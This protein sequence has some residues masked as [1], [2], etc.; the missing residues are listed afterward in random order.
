MFFTDCASFLISTAAGIADGNGT[1]IVRNF[2][3]SVVH[4]IHYVNTRF[5]VM[6]TFLIFCV[7][8]SIKHCIPP[9]FVISEMF[10]N[11]V[12]LKQLL[13]VPG[14]KPSTLVLNLADLVS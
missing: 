11:V 9:E 1:S 3:L 5:K 14:T 7:N 4:G 10:T 13:G 6:Y 12:G 2:L 8:I